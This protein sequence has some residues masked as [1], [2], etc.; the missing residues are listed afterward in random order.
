MIL[1]VS[2][3]NNSYIGYITVSTMDKIIYIVTQHVR[4]ICII[5]LFILTYK[6]EKYSNPNKFQQNFITKRCN[7]SKNE[8]KKKHG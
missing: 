5:Y 2:S 4:N 8:V 6:K 1:R 7:K 3:G